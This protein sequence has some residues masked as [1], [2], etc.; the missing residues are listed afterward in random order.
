MDEWRGRIGWVVPSWNTV[1]EYEVPRLTPVGTSN[2]FTR[3]RHT[4]DSTEAFSAM[5]DAGPEAV[6]LL[7]HC[8]PEAIVFACT[9]ATFFRGRAAERELA[10]RLSA[11][12]DAPVV[13]MAT[14]IV[15][16][17]VE[18]KAGR[19]VVA[20]PYEPWLGDLL[21][22]YVREA[23][24]D[25]LRSAFLGEQANVEHGPDKARELA[26]RAWH[27]GSDA[28]VISCGNFRTLESIESIERDFDVPVV[29]SIAAA[30]WSASRT[31]NLGVR[32]DGPGR[33]FRSTQEPS[34]VHAERRP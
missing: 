3:I 25:V 19:V 7:G 28:I 33:L 31:A 21:V 26:A 24:F 14:A 6:E 29:T 9:A 30:A 34:I 2:H 20:A 5:K 10:D 8:Q 16:A 15:D 32:A 11:A 18:V 27:D 1:T 12:V 4:E 23:G 13:T 17:L 22:R